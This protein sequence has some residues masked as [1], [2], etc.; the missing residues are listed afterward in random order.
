MIRLPDIALPVGAA[1]ALSRYQADVDKADTYGAQVEEAKRLF[2]LR[3]KKG[4]AAFDAVKATLEQMCCGAKRCAYCE[5]SM[6]D[7]VE[8]VRPKDLYPQVVFRWT[9]YVN[10][11]G[12]CNGPKGNH[13][14]VLPAGANAPVEVARKP[15]DPVAPPRD[16]VPAFIDPRCEDATAVMILDLQGTFGF[17]PLAAKGTRDYVRAAYTIKVLKLNRPI[18]TRARGQAYVDYFNFVR[19]YER[20]RDSKSS[21]A[22]LRYLVDTLRA[23]QHPTVWREM[24]RQREKLPELQNLFAAVPEAAAW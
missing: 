3:N 24:Q 4:N 21:A 7:E 6:A 19:R 16:G 20:D 12:P 23:R 14:A 17:A 13:F 1:E 10:A 18:L 22:H 15:N 11:C 9:N 8:H 5:D 2:G